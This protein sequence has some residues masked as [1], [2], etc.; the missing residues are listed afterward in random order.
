M[1]DKAFCK[2]EWLVVLAD[3]LWSGNANLYPEYTSVSVRIIEAGHCYQPATR[4]LAIL[5]NTAILETQHR[6]LLLAE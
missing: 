2:S 4:W 1:M 6:T 5:V 3:A